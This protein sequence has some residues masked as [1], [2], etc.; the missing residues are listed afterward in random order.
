MLRRARTHQSKHQFGMCFVSWMQLQN[1]D[2]DDD[3]DDRNSKIKCF[4]SNHH[5]S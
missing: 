1:S 5:D 2:D 3:D 4:S